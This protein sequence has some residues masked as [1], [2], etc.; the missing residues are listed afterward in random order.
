MLLGLTF[1][2]IIACA[3]NIWYISW[4]PLKEKVWQKQFWVDG[5][6]V[7]SDTILFSAS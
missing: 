7:I 2:N 1:V 3:R 4:W 5:M 6:W